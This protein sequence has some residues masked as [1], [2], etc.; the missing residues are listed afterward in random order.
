MYS[1][2]Q[3]SSSSHLLDL[4][5][6][7]KM[8]AKRRPLWQMNFLNAGELAAFSQKRGVS[9]FEKEDIMQFWQLGFL[10]ADLIE[11]GHELQETGLVKQDNDEYSQYIYSDERLLAIHPNGWDD[12]VVN[13]ALLPSDVEPLF[14]PFRYYVLY[15]L[16]RNLPRVSNIG[17]RPFPLRGFAVPDLSWFKVWS[18]STDFVETITSWNDV[19]A[20][21]TLT[22]PYMYER[23][24]GSLGLDMY[25][26]SRG[27]WQ[28]LYKQIEQLGQE[29]IQCYQIIGIK[30][31]QAIYQEL[32]EAVHKLDPNEKIH[33]LICLGEGEIRLKLEGRLGG[34]IHLRSMAEMLRRTIEVTFPQQLPE[35]DVGRFGVRPGVGDYKEALYGSKRLLDG[36]RFVANEFLKQLGLNFGF[37]LHW[38]VEGKTEWGALR[39]YFQR[40]KI[41]EID[42][43][44]LHGE[45]VQ[46]GQRGIAFRESLRSDIQMEVYSIVSIDGDVPENARVVRKAAEDDE[47][48]GAFYIFTPD[49]EFANFEIW[50]LEAV[51]WEIAKENGASLDDRGKL[52][53]AVQGSGNAETLLRNVKRSLPDALTH[54]T[55]NILWGERLMDFA[56]ASRFKQGRKRPILEAID[57]AIFWTRT[58]NLESYKNTRRELQV[59]KDTGKLVKRSS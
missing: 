14:H 35:E 49:F 42:V 22:E 2:L 28:E 31:L 8:L 19:S 23:V 16:E 46:R 40:Y 24:F 9:F 50:E 27:S 51:L 56:L 58:S 37:R 1:L 48:C 38:Y 36:D 52:H 18:S 45:V 59:D 3:P 47:I 53:N 13:L 39:R 44:D 7:G 55:K 43:I 41:T 34:A 54:V 20:L 11:S 5:L 25:W 29:I 15:Q 57:E 10:Q 32:C 12:E 4:G 33:T 26:M 6:L 17:E 30:R 21:I